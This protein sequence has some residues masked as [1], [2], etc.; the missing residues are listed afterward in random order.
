MFALRK[1]HASLPVCQKN[2]VSSAKISDKKRSR[3]VK[4]A[5]SK[6]VEKGIC[7]EAQN[8]NCENGE[9]SSEFT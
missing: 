3:V 6:H 8:G 7:C 9:L 2:A 1:Q 5:G 4:S